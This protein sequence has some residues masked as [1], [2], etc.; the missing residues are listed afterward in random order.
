MAELSNTR[1]ASKKVS[2]YNLPNHKIQ[3]EVLLSC[4]ISDSVPNHLVRSK[5]VP[6]LNWAPRHADA[7]GNGVQLH[8]FFNLG[9]R[10]RFRWCAFV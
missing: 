8:A 4:D 7:L 1:N 5:C 3:I 6:V 2:I 10:W 9:T